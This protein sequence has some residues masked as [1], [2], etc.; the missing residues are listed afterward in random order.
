MTVGSIHHI[1]IWVPSYERAVESYGWVLEALGYRE[2][3]NWENACSW[4]LGQTYIVI[5]ESP[6]IVGGEHDRLRPGVNHLA[7]NAGS[8]E[9]LDRLVNGAL[10][11]GWALL[12]ANQHPFAG[13]PEHH[14]AFLENEDGFEIE[15]V[16]DTKPT[17]QPSG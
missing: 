12:F 11:H 17:D 13:G 8:P 16:A 10:G 6:A 14:A 3:R 9:D 5:E 4:Q 2:S 7:F 1:E 15:L